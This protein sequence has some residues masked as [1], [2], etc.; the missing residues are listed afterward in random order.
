MC[1]AYMTCFRP[2]MLIITREVCTSVKTFP[3]TGLLIFS[4]CVRAKPETGFKMTSHNRVPHLGVCL[5]S[6]NTK[7]PKTFLDT[8]ITPNTQRHKAKEY[9]LCK[10][11]DT[12]GSSGRTESS[13]IT[14]LDF[15]HDKLV[16]VPTLD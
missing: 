7:S 1:G 12:T 13:K 10:A 9:Q 6:R 8:S 5:V 15:L 2:E 4:C 16:L 3:G 14:W 11:K